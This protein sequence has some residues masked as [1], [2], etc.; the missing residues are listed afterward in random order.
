M[1]YTDI[2]G[3][4]KQSYAD[5]VEDLVPSNVY[6]AK[7]AKP[8]PT[9]MQPGGG[10][11]VSVNLSSE[12]GMTKAAS[13]AGAFALNAPVSMASRFATVM[14]NQYLLRSALDLESVYNSKNKNAFVAA[15][16]GVIENMLD[17]MWNE[18]EADC[19]YGRRSK[20]TLSGAAGTVLTVSTAT[21]AS[22]LWLGSEGRQIRLETAAGVL[23]GTA[24]IS[25]YD[26]EA[27]T[28][29]TDVA[30]PG[31]AAT[32][33]LYFA[34]DGATAANTMV[35]IMSAAGATTGLLW[36]LNRTTWQLWSPATAYAVG[37]VP[38][39]FNHA[40]RAITRAANRGLGDKI[41]EIDL[42]VNPSTFTDLANDFA[43]LKTNDVSYKIEE[44]HN[45]SEKLTF[46]CP[47]GK[48][49]VIQHKM[50]ME[51]NALIHP[52]ASKCF[53]MVGSCPKPD[54]AHP[55]L[56]KNGEKEY[57]R[58]MENNAGVEARVYTNCAIFTPMISKCLLV[59]GIVNS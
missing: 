33:L 23:R 58:P 37:G 12:Q 10:Y 21:W 2:Q 27:R 5:K 17:S 47:A 19:L 22:G 1:A 31:A 4:F 14:G 43:A 52:K 7:E 41:N 48:V 36:G 16:K 38:F 9:E 20:G 55:G 56:T 45:G 25:T 44:G 51:G 29:T 30:I 59:S 11:N 28:I 53:S 35:G 46:H 34:A 13:G 49:S 50:M 57:L 26:I 24:T 40:M 6:Y 3:W 18:I 15:T 8:L 39:S 32:D 54:F 42:V